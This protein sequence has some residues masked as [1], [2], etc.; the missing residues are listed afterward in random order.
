MSKLYDP[1]KVTLMFDGMAVSGFAED[2]MINM[3]KDEE[4]N[5]MYNGAQGEVSISKNANNIW[6]MTVA[7]A[8]TSPFIGILRDKALSDEPR[9]PISVIN[10]NEG[11]EDMSSSTAIVTTPPAYMATTEIEGVEVEIKVHDPQFN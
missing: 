8:S 11:H 4:A 2:S 10:M 5:T 6:T 9:A 3:E 1:R 7:L